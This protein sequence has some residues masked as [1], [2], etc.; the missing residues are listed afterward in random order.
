MRDYHS[1]IFFIGNSSCFT[2]G[3]SHVRNSYSLEVS[4]L[5]IRAISIFPSQYN[6]DRPQTDSRYICYLALLS[7]CFVAQGG[8]IGMRSQLTSDHS[9]IRLC[10]IRR[11]SSLVDLTMSH[12]QTSNLP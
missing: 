3:A 7:S 12:L 4:L 5:H 10:D 6:N 1:L 2:R 8:Y 11:H 9:Y